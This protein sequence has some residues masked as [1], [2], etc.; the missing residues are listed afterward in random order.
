[1][2]DRLE[3]IEGRSEYLRITWPTYLVGA[4]YE[5]VVNTFHFLAIL[6]ILSIAHLRK[7]AKDE[8]GIQS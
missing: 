3:R 7:P 8:P 4:A 2:V 1:M 6:R 5:R